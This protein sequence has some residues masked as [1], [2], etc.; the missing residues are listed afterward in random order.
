LN[1]L[2]ADGEVKM[3][4]FSGGD[5]ASEILPLIDYESIRRHPKLFSSYSDATSILLA[6]HAQTGLV[7]YYGMGVNN[8]NDL[9]HYD[10]TQFVSHFVEGH[11]A[12][13]FEKDSV[14]RTLRG[15]A[16]EGTLM[17]GYSSLFALTMGGGYFK[18]EDKKYILVIEDHEKYSSP[19]TFN[20][21]LSFIE[22]TP[23]MKNVVGLIMG[24][25]ALEVPET[26]INRLTRFGG[27]NGIPVVYT[28]DFGH[29]TKHAI[30][31]IGGLARLDANKQTLAFLSE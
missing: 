14:W 15:G 17:G 18:F 9:R 24:H 2:V 30:F 13:E 5:G 31:P 16:C 27:N 25:Y 10:Y 29:G 20:S 11:E 19:N 8:F 1:A 26:L 4:L 6:V 7:T 23:I 22:Q 28:D 12:K 21:Y 3:I